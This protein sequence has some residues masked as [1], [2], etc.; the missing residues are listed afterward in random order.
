MAPNANPAWSSTVSGGMT[1]ARVFST[2]RLK[3]YLPLGDIRLASPDRIWGFMATQ[4]AQ[5]TAART[6]SDP[7]RAPVRAP[8]SVARLRPLARLLAVWLLAYVLLLQSVL[9]AAAMAT[10]T[11]TGTVEGLC[12][13]SVLDG[14]ADG[15]AHPD[16]PGPHDRAPGVHC[17]LCP[18]I[19]GTP[20]LPA[21]PALP[22]PFAVLTAQ[23]AGTVIVLPR[24]VLP[25]GEQA[26]P[27]APP[28]A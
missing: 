22:Q 21:G 27:R 20:A 1:Q 24:A 5:R 3:S 10:H 23:E 15:V 14:A 13:S 8:G 7:V 4:R 11:A 26:R 12:L 6:G 19:G 17:A 16:D 25:A 9:G 2:P 28:A 18:A